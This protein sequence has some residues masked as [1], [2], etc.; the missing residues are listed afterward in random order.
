MQP[1]GSKAASPNRDYNL[2][3]SDAAGNLKPG[4]GRSQ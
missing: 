4:V 3:G 2:T 1:P